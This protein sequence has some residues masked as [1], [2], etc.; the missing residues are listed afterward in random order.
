MRLLHVLLPLALLG[1]G[2]IAPL[3][4]DP[5]TETAAIAPP[6]ERIDGMTAEEN[7][8]DKAVPCDGGDP[9]LLPLPSSCAERELLVV[10]RIGVEQLPVEL[11][12]N[13]GAIQIVTTSDDSWS[14]HAVVKVRVTGSDDAKSAIDDAWTWTHEEDGKH[15]LKA[16][17]TAREGVQLPALPGAARAQVVASRYEV[18]LPAWVVLDLVAETTNGGVKAEGV[19]ADSIRAVTTNGGIALAAR[20]ASVAAETTNGGIDVALTPTASGDVSLRTTNGGISLLVP[21][22]SR[23]GYDVRAD[24]TNGRI[25][26]ELSDGDT[27][28]EQGH[29]T[30]RSDDYDARPVKTVVA[31]ET[32][33]GRIVVEPM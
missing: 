6:L 32:T 22:G 23:Y 13:N 33:N 25:E 20:A 14:F 8:T 1:A 30:F 24:T 2:C 7:I 12:A 28:A 16:A 19:T 3:E 29:A 10:G 11:I 27:S 21:E 15:V 9:G 5:E 18:A 17:P 26:I 4:T 31:L